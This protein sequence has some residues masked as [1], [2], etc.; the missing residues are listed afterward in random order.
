MLIE[1][2]FGRTITDIYLIS[3]I[4]QGWLDTADCIIELDN[5]LLI[6]IPVGHSLDIWERD[7][8]P[9]AQSLFINLSDIPSYHVNKKGK[10]ISEVANAYQKRKNSFLG[11][12]KKALL[13]EEKIPKEYRPYK[14]EYRENKLKYIQ[15]AK[16]A[17]YLWYDE[18]GESGFFLL[19]NGYIISEKRMAPSGTGM[20]GLHYFESLGYLEQKKGGNYK[21]LSDQ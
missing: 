21:R 2:I 15:H 12:I 5:Q 8:E 1:D 14:V 7:P 10:S 20:A 19:D 16:I 3:G 6:G 17:D 9:L 4:E 18:D 13:G 11:K